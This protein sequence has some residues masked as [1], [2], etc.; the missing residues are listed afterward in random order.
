MEVRSHAF[1]PCEDF[2]L[3]LWKRRK[4]I[5]LRCLKESLLPSGGVLT[6]FSG[7]FWGPVSGGCFRISGIFAPPRLRSVRNERR[8]GSHGPWDGWFRRRRFSTGAG[9]QRRP[10]R[11]EP[12]ADRDVGC[13]LILEES[14][15]PLLLRPIERQGTN[16]PA[17]G[18]TGGGIGR[19]NAPLNF[20]WATSKDQG[21]NTRV[22]KLSEELAAEIRRRYFIAGSD[23]ARKWRG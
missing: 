2:L 17:H 21:R 22:V 12:W 8:L 9:A 3:F 14:E 23:L 16:E 11:T 4:V 20:E 13:G 15:S 7:R 6:R 5:G 1:R 10:R 18:D 19:L